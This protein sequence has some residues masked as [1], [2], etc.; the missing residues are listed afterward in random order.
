MQSLLVQLSGA[1]AVL[2]HLEVQG[3]SIN[4]KGV[5]ST[6]ADIKHLSGD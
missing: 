3:Q 5:G 4:H 2:S 1:G 6:R